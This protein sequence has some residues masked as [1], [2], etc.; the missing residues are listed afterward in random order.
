MTHPGSLAPRVLTV[1]EHRVS[2]CVRRG[3]GGGRRKKK[4][5]GRTRLNVGDVARREDERS[6]LL[7]QL[8][9]LLLEGEVKLSVAGNVASA[10]R[11]GAIS[12]ERVAAKFGQLDE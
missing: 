9:Q 5:K 6:G 8:G 4:G 11:S 10:S 3:G 12:V 2:S 7:V 1:Y